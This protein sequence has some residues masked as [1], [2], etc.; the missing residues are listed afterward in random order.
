MFPTHRPTGT[1]MQLSPLASEN[2]ALMRRPILTT[3]QAAI[4]CDL[5]EV[6]GNLLCLRKRSCFSFD[7][8]TLREPSA[9]AAGQTFASPK[10]HEQQ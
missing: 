9:S 2:G 7:Y 1:V 3:I 5:T 8:A 6:F 4:Q 10:E